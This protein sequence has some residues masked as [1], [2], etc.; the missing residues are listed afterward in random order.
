MAIR[1]FSQLEGGDSNSM[2][3][4]PVDTHPKI[5]QVQMRLLSQAGPGR[6]LELTRALSQGTIEMSRRALQRRYP[7]LSERKIAL[8][9]LALCYGEELAR[10]VEIHLES[11][12]T[13]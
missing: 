1:I 8:K 7:Q 11:R 6:R 10:R 13:S 9:L 3:S 2:K 12:R 5:E 4:H